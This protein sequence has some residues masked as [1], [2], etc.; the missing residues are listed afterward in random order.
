MKVG[1][2]VRTQGT[3]TRSQQ[4][5]EA[6]VDRKG[7]V[8]GVFL[9]PRSIRCNCTNACYEGIVTVLWDGDV[10]AHIFLTLDNLVHL[11]RQ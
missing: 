7:T 6:G 8:E 4:N 3:T 10:H 1:A 11:C 9:Q 2:R 5:W